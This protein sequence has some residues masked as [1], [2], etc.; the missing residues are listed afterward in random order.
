LGKNGTGNEGYDRYMAIISEYLAL[1]VRQPLHPLE[2]RHPEINPPEETPT[3]ATAAPGK[4]V[5]SKMT[6]L[7][8]DT[9]IVCR[10]LKQLNEIILDDPIFS[11]N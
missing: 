1:V 6:I 11:K 4:R 9:A 8:A 7:C 5:T 3:S 10:G 2:V